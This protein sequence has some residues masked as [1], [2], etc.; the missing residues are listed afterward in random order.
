VY[1]GAHGRKRARCQ[2]F[3]HAN[4]RTPTRLRIILQPRAAWYTHPSETQKLRVAAGF[5]GSSAQPPE[6]RRGMVFAFPTDMSKPIPTVAK[7]MTMTPHTVGSDQTLQHAH[8]LMQDND[9]RHLPVLH[10]GELVG[11]L[12]ERDLALIETFNGVDP[13]AVTIDRAMST[14]VYQVAPETP[15]DEVVSG[16]ASKKYGSAVV[17]QNRKV[18]GILTTVDVCTA[19]AEL[20]KGRLAS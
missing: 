8:L 16:M 19:L 15:L 2:A 20:L 17:V 12:T 10:N 5:S 13:R 11:M 3:S 9:I 18:V 1:G 14:S 6:F 4:D 7:Y